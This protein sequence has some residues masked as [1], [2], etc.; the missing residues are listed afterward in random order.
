MLEA[1]ELICHS[2]RPRCVKQ[3]LAGFDILGSYCH[4]CQ[5]KRRTLRKISKPQASGLLT[6]IQRAGEIYWCRI[7][8]G[9]R[10]VN[11]SNSGPSVE[12]I[13]YC[14]YPELYCLYPELY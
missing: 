8:I 12:I 13:I 2:L 5:Q 14:L 3:K 10:R 9:I 7:R 6:L 1:M 11:P 4:F